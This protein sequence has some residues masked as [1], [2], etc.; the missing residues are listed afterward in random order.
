MTDRL[1]DMP[2][3]AQR[4]DAIDALHYNLWRRAR[5]RFGVPLRLPLAGLKGIE[6]ILDDHAWICV[7]A[8]QHDLP[9]L[10]WISIE[11]AGRDALHTPVACTLNYYHFA[12]SALRA[13]VLDLMARELELRLA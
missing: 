11:A 4:A 5:L 1:A 7:D 3:Y 8:T 9:V 12:A 10:A 6:L 2:I 13:R